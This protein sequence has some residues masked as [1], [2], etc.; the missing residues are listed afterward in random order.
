MRNFTLLFFCVPFFVFGQLSAEQENEISKYKSIID[1]DVHDSIKVNALINWDNIIY[2]FD[3]V[4]DS[5]ILQRIISLCR[6]TLEKK[7]TAQEKRWF[8][9]ELADG[10]N[11]RGASATGLGHYKFAIQQFKK[12]IP[13]YHQAGITKGL[14][15][16]TINLGT[17]LYDDGNIQ[18]AIIQFNAGIKLTDK[19]GNEQY[20]ANAL[21]SLGNIYLDLDQIDKSLEY[22]HKANKLAL[23]LDA[24]SS[25]EVIYLNMGNAYLKKGDLDS[26]L[27]CYSTS[28]Q[29][30][31]ELNDN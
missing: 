11:Y 9:I 18:E 7:L 3:P 28:L 24:K 26:S 5:T 1:S 10:L 31:K 15:G 8:T 22:F 21:M 6:H 4:Q 25:I 27:F 17:A 14:D 2:S 19:T 23:A 13:F 20:K 30:G 16:C 29:Y 12:A